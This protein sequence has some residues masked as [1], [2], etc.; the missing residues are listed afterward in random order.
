MGEIVDIVAG[1]VKR[2]LVE[3]V[4]T[5]KIGLPVFFEGKISAQKAASSKFMEI[6]VGSGTIELF[7]ILGS[8]N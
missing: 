2:K 1:G 5:L 6:K 4:P 3:E 7:I 8:R